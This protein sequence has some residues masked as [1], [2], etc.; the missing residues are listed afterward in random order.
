ME[1]EHVYMSGLWSVLFIIGF[2][3]F[4]IVAVSITVWVFRQ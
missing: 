2:T 1:H 4:L 3:I